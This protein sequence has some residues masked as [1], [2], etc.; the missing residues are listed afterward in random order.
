[1]NMKARVSLQGIPGTV[2][3]TCPGWVRVQWDAGHAS[4]ISGRLLWC[5]L[6]YLDQPEAEPEPAPSLDGTFQLA[7]ALEF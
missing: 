3:E 7:L 2:V 5:P 6:S 4:E 1:M